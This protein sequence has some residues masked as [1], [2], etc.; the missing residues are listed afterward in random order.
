M[1]HPTTVLLD[2]EGTTT[3]IAFVHRTLFPYARAALPDLVTRRAG[4]PEIAGALAEIDRL[5]PGADPVAQLLAWMDDDAKITPLKTLQGLAWRDGYAAG[6]LTGDLYPDVAP[7][8]ARWHA[9]GLRLAIYSS[10]SEEAQRLIFAHTATGDLT[11]LLDRFFDT[12]IGTKRDPASYAAL[13]RR[14]KSE[15][16]AI[17]FLSDVAA[18]LDAAAV[19]GL[20]TCQLVRAQDGT[21]PTDRHPTAADLD[22]VAT[23]FAL[24]GAGATPTS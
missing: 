13:A 7:A 5:A 18:E 11:P 2:I 14:L 24:P 4:E 17:L 9:A 16:D 20:H 22:Q 6:E 10:G 1:P 23:L 8:L 21:V 19:A 15:P 12:R 3:P